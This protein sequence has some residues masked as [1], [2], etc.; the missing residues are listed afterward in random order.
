MIS[1]IEWIGKLYWIPVPLAV[2]H[3]AWCWFVAFPLFLEARIREGKAWVYLPIWWSKPVHSW[4]YP[5]T[6]L[7][8][9][10]NVLWWTSATYHFLP[11]RL[12]LLLAFLL[13]YSVV[14]LMLQHLWLRQN[15]HLQRECYFKEYRKLAHQYHREGKPM[16]DVDLRNRTM[17][18][19]QNSLRRA[20]KTKRFYKYLVRKASSKKVPT[21]FDDNLE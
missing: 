18:E 9:S 2:A 8:F 11:Q 6:L 15:Y 20:D 12:L 19:H 21:P 1:T 14:F 5:G 10:L 4:I 3:W 7:L 17:W 16:S 13:V